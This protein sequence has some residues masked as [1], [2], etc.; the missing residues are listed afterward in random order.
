MEK[1]RIM[2]VE[3]DAAWMKKITDVLLEEES[4]IIEETVTTQDEAINKCISG[5]IDIVLI[6]V[7]LGENPDGGVSAIKTVLREKNQKFIMLA[8]LNDNN[9][10]IECYRSGAM[11][12]VLKSELE[13]L[14]ATIFSVYSSRRS[15]SIIQQEFKSL[16]HEQKKF[17][18]LSK[19]EKA[20]FDLRE[21]GLSISQIAE[22]L[23]K[24]PRTIKNQFRNMFRKF[25]V[26]NYEELH[27]YIYN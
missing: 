11:D 20:A 2:V 22:E 8:S 17:L 13:K 12:Y 24:S 26:E 1:I 7:A 21:K 19:E 10:I 3:N 27:D 9:T 4:F 25:N 16:I 14:P 6:D 18:L 23:Q 15:Q 5:N